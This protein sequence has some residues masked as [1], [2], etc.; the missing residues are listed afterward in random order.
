MYFSTWWRNLIFEEQ[1][2]F[3][4]ND[5]SER[6]NVPFCNELDKGYRCLEV[7]YREGKQSC[8]QPDFAKSDCNFKGKETL[9][10]TAV[11][12]DRSGNERVVRLS[13]FKKDN[14][15]SNFGIQRGRS[16]RHLLRYL[17]PSCPLQKLNG[18]VP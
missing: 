8:I 5:M 12:T 17:C 15:K 16:F 11:A 10:S 18:E 9:T 4:K 13:N 3:A 1:R 2:D 14:I 7:A 6:W